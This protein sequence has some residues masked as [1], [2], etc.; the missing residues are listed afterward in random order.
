MQEL[1][2]LDG[3]TDSTV[4]SAAIGWP[5]SPI[6]LNNTRPT[7]ISTNQTES[8]ALEGAHRYS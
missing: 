4:A 6:I 5:R 1:N 3:N 2:L 7:S 8:P